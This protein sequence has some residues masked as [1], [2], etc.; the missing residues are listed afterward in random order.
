MA[1]EQKSGGRTQS[2]AAAK[3][4][5]RPTYDWQKHAPTISQMSQ[6]ELQ[7][8]LSKQQ[9]LLVWI[10]TQ[11]KPDVQ[12]QIERKIAELEA[13][14]R[15]KE[16]GHALPEAGKNQALPPQRHSGSTNMD[17]AV[18]TPQYVKPRKALPVLSI[19]ETRALLQSKKIDSLSEQ[20]AAAT[21]QSDGAPETK[22]HRVYSG[23]NVH[24][25]ASHSTVPPAVLRDTVDDP[26]EEDAGIQNG[27]I[28]A[29]KPRSR[30]M[31]DDDLDVDDPY[32]VADEEDEYAS[33]IQL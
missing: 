16:S 19:D 32:A 11:H 33:P 27:P 2:T 13:A 15:A 28:A 18:T 12:A 4:F 17:I 22:A 20:S 26:M 10:R 6:S 3:G 5:M 23:P 14:L 9:S 21:S 31:D 1:S 8:L 7:S 25:N 29:R 30:D 24:P